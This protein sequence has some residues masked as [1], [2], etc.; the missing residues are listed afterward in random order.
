MTS[1]EIIERHYRRRSEDERRSTGVNRLE[2][3]RIE[4]LLLRFL[5]DA[6]A[7][8]RDVGGG[9]GYYASILAEADYEVHLVDLVPHHIDQA[10]HRVDDR[11]GAELAD[12]D[13]GDARDLKWDDASSDA[14]L[15]LGPLYHL[16]DR[17]DRDR[18]L[19]EARRVLRPGGRLMA[20]SISRFASILEGLNHGRFDDPT[21]REI[22][23]RDLNTGNHDNPTGDPEYFTESYYHL[24]D[25][26]CDE[27]E[28]AGFEVDQILGIE[29]PGWL[30]G[31]F[32][33]RWEDDTWRRRFVDTARRLEDE[34]NLLGA[35]V[36]NMLVA[37]KPTADHST[38]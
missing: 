9:P 12:A 22:A 37:T 8:V 2:E 36:H 23:E 26:L 35:S 11:P 16:Q 7:V 17:A 4:Q 18:A 6:P 33:E 5:P 27:V 21:F 34:P 30:A 29:G 32:N 10:L 19:A 1:E 25:E 20:T 3:I 13:I 28:T 14:V 24:P 31:D 15:L 38:P